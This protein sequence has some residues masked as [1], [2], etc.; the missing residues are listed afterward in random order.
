MD[1]WQW[2]ILIVL[3]LVTLVVGAAYLLYRAWLQYTN[4]IDDAEKQYLLD[5]PDLT[6][7]SE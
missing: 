5:H 7:K 6:M 2:V 3:V 4:G 1:W